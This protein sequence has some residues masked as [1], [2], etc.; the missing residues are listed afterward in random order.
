VQE[1]PT[2]AGRLTRTIA[3]SRLTS[4]GGRATSAL[5]KVGSESSARRL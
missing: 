2:P 3:A 1:A 5:R 4:A